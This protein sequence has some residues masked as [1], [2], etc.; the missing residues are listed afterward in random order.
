M[1]ENRWFPTRLLYIGYRDSEIKLIV[2]EYNRPSGPYVTLS[3]CWG[4]A[5]FLHLLEENMDSFIGGTCF[6]SLPKTFSDAIGV[7]RRM[8]VS[9]IWIDSLC[10]IQDSRSDWLKEAAQMHEVYSNS[11]C[12]MSATGATDSSVGLFFNRNIADLYPC[13]I[14]I[15]WLGNARYNIY[16]AS[17]W[18]T[19]ID[20]APLTRRG[21]ACQER[22]LAPRVLHLSRRPLLRECRAPAAAEQYPRGLPPAMRVPSALFKGFDP[23]THG[24]ELRR[25]TQEPSQDPR[26]HACQLRNKVV[27]ACSRAQLTKAADKPVAL[28][29]VAQRMRA[30]SGGDEHVAGLCGGTSRAGWCGACRRSARGTGGRPRAV[31]RVGGARRGRHTEQLQRLRGAGRGEE[32]RGR[33]RHGR[34]HGA[35]GGWAPGSR[36]HAEA[37]GAQAE[38]RRGE[39]VGDVGERRVPVSEDGAEELPRCESGRQPGLVSESAVCSERRGTQ[40]LADAE[41]AQGPDSG[42][43]SVFDSG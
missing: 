43:D 6:D 11:F 18:A 16:H 39:L 5:R 22:Q 21:W 14:P 7:F 27:A 37:A 34:R 24:A 42:G 33:A 8:G 30:V 36:G 35:G 26:F 1:S 40:L 29:G 4:R 9:Y 10:I 17:F 2:T 25:L 32:R 38:C 3:H 19:H 12:N 31:V 23:R 41:T 20:D 15:P 13:I 28:S